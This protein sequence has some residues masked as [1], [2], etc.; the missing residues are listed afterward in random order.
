ML[1]TG[2]SILFFWLIGIS[3]LLYY[4]F[5]HGAKTVVLNMLADPQ[6]ITLI[7]YALPVIGVL[8]SLQLFIGFLSLRRGKLDTWKKATAWIVVLLLIAGILVPSG[9]GSYYAYETRS[10]MS[11][12]FKE[13]RQENNAVRPSVS[14]Q[15]PWA[16]VPRLN[17]LAL[18]SDAGAGRIGTR[19]DVIMVLSVNPQSGRTDMFN[20]PRNLRHTPFPDNT[21]GAEA[22][23]SGFTDEE[24]LINS[25]W[26]WGDNHSDLFPGDPSPGLTATEHAVE[27]ALGLEIDYSLS[28]NMQG[29][30]DLV[31]A[32]GGV[33]VDVPRD[34]PKAKEGVIPDEYVIAGENRKLDG[35]D[36]L[37]YVRSRAGSSDYDRMERTRCMVK[38]LTDEIDPQVLATKYTNFLS[39]LKENFIT[40]IPQSDI[41]A[42]ANLFSRIQQ[43]G[44]EGVALTDDVITPFNP[45]YDAIHAI[46]DEYISESEQTKPLPTAGN[47]GVPYVV[48]DYNNG[49]GA[50]QEEETSEPESNEEETSTDLPSDGVIVETED[51]DEGSSVDSSD[52][53]SEDL[54]C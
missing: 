25:V 8:W 31:D 52:E 20:I 18:G 24:G 28:L 4:V 48:P 23:P 14:H 1:K 41:S 54:Y 47:S 19:P 26:T 37:W 35:D 33:T 44:I 32:L 40:D 46:V 43:G 27:G 7:M 42:W 21:P 5:S 38:A 49:G 22:F 9:M 50:P 53:N 30:E 36:A 6:A 29:F 12:V 16:N 51:S 10:T 39:I 15:D 17:I 3:G 2:F 45:D 13:H 11:T 34:L